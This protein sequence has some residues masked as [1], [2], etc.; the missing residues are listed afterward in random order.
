M[1]IGE[2]G[3]VAGEA[4]LNCGGDLDVW[5]HKDSQRHVFG[6]VPSTISHQEGVNE[7]LLLIGVLVRVLRFAFASCF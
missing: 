6:L 4:R 5:V 7:Q 3:D 1:L 2:L